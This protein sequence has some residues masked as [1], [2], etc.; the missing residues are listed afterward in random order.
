MDNSYD[1]E[2]VEFM[3]LPKVEMIYED[4]GKQ[5]KEEAADFE[6]MTNF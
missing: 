2:N 3:L 6:S 1:M 4:A 5:V